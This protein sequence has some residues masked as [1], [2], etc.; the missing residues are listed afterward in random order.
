MIS[1]KLKSILILFI[2][3]ISILLLT[4]TVSSQKELVIISPSEANEGKSFILNIR[5]SSKTGEIVTNVNIILQI[6]YSNDYHYIENLTFVSANRTIFTPHAEKNN[7]IMT[8]TATKTGYISNSTKVTIIDIPELVINI[9]SYQTKDC[10]YIITIYDEYNNKIEGAKVKIS[11]PE[12]N[13]NNSINKWMEEIKNETYYSDENAQIKFYSPKAGILYSVHA[14]KKGYQSDYYSLIDK[15]YVRYCDYHEDF[16]QVI[17][18]IF[19]LS[20]LFLLSMI[21]IRFVHGKIEIEKN[22][23]Q[24]KF[25]FAILTFFILISFLIN[26]VSGPNIAGF[27]LFLVLPIS[28]SYIGLSLQF[29]YQ[30]NLK[31]I[32]YK[33]YKL[34]GRIITYIISIFMLLIFGFYSILCIGLSADYPYGV[35]D[36]FL[37]GCIQIGMIFIFAIFLL[38][39]NTHL[40]IYERKQ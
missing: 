8:I 32:H 26:F 25:F 6:N 22:K 5:N 35:G 33:K 21:L 30:L 17:P 23:K 31:N 38:V 3:L 34:A 16:Y 24:I 1:K 7:N 27:L 20:A 11:Y 10:S 39:I 37:S 15:N 19:S 29:F 9:T 4:N 14:S 2:F 40:W 18:I 28:L 13:Y 12:Y 36:N